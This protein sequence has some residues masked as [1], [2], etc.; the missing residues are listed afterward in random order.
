MLNLDVICN[1]EI[2]FKV[3]IEYVNQFGV[4][5]VV[6]GYYVDLKCDEVGNMYLMWVKD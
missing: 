2:K 5:Y 4:D 6:I 1:K 3:F